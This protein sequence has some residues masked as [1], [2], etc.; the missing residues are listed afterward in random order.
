MNLTIHK[1]SKWQVY[2]ERMSHLLNPYLCDLR[3]IPY[4]EIPSTDCE[5]MLK[6]LLEYRKQFLFSKQLKVIEHSPR[7]MY[8]QFN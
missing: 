2:H 3:H 6:T 4:H 8:S 7:F 1:N 5:R